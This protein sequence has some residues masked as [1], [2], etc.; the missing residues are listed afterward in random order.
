[1]TTEARPD[2]A[3][4]LTLLN[5]MPKVDFATVTAEM[6]RTMNV[7]LIGMAEVERGPL[8]VV[9]DLSIPGPAGNIPARLYDTREDRAPGPVM[10]FYHGGGFVIGD[11]NTYDSYCA[12][13]A[14]SLDMPVISIDYRLSPE[15]PWPAAPDDCEAATRWIAE[16]IPCTGLITS[17]DSAGGNLAI[18][19][20]MAL[21]DNPAAVPVIAQF[22]IYPVVADHNDWPSYYAHNEGKLLTAEVMDWFKDCYAADETSRR[23]APLAF[24]HSGMPPTVIITATLDPLL[25]QGRAYA[26]ALEA[27][28]VPT[29]YLEA[30]GNI[31]GCFQLRKAIPSTAGD[32]ARALSALKEMVSVEA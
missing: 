28:G 4:F 12:E 31:H 13:A 20:T 6:M 3:A 23:A 27:A 24:D 19:T 18:V 8:A 9:K 11:L 29:T 32:V 22:P 2:V 16:N 30:E 14:R 17:G 21:R 5:S 7:T 26:E 10:V 25:D 1:M 15:H